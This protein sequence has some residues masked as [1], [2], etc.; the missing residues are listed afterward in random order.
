M[1]P[2]PGE[3]CQGTIGPHYNP[4]NVSL[5]SSNPIG[6][7][8]DDCSPLS[9]LRCESGDLS[10]KHGQLTIDSP[11]V[12]MTTYSYLDPNLNLYGPDAHTSKS[13]A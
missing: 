13:F 10:G 1:P 6:N 2:V 5:D 8:S 4:F 7:Y 12:N 9:K 3:P 11:G